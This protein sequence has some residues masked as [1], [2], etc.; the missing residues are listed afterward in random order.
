MYFF[1]KIYRRRNQRGLVVL[2]NGYTFCSYDYVLNFFIFN[3]ICLSFFPKLNTY[4]YLMSEIEI[5]VCLDRN[6]ILN[7]GLKGNLVQVTKSLI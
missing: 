5:L 3:L 4:G 1:S 7:E 6:L 2:N